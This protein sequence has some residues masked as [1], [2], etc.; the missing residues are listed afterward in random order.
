MKKDTT[1]LLQ[2]LLALSC[3]GLC[4]LL[5]PQVSQAQSNPLLSPSEER[6]LLGTSAGVA[7]SFI[8]F[9][10][11]Y[12]IA[13]SFDEEDPGSNTGL[14]FGS[15]LLL[16]GITVPLSVWVV[17]NK[18]LGA[19]KSYPLALAGFGSGLLLNFLLGIVMST[20]LDDSQEGEQISD[21][22][23]I[24][25]AAVFLLTPVATTVLFYETGLNF[26]QDEPKSPVA[27]MIQ[28]LQLSF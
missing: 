13:T 1:H 25:F 14:V 16:S 15:W 12:F 18:F 27:T 5:S 3:F 4:L 10:L 26:E 21:I 6:I 20:T 28:L 2:S 9:G 22:S 24:L 23:A 19:Q 11:T 7:A 17:G 8:S